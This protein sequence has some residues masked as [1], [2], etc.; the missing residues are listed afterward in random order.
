[1]LD[2]IK[3]LLDISETFIIA[4]ALVAPL[5]GMSISPTLPM[6]EPAE[7]NEFQGGINGINA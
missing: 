1:M 5:A 6:L 3:A 4:M 7:E 2:I